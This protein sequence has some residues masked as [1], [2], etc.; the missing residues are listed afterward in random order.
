MGSF[1]RGGDGFSAN[2]AWWNGT[3][4]QGKTLLLGLPRETVAE[5]CLK[6][7][8]HEEKSKIRDFQ[9]LALYSNGH[10]SITGEAMRTKF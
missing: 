7:R 4:K 2:Q 5:N 3:T 10:I 9:L 1:Q 8:N 6:Q